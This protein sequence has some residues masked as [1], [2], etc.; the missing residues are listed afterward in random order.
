MSANED[1]E[2]TMVAEP[3]IL[4]SPAILATYVERAKNGDEESF[5]KLVECFSKLILDIVS[6]E[7][8]CKEDVE[9]IWLETFEKA[10]DKLSSLRDTLKF[11]S[12]L[13]AIARHLSR[14]YLRRKREVPFSSLEGNGE[15]EGQFEA[16]DEKAERAY[17]DVIKVLWAAELLTRLPSRMQ[18]C[19][20]LADQYGYTQRQ[21]AE[22]LGISEKTVSVYLSQAREKLR[23][24]KHEWESCESCS[25]QAKSRE[26]A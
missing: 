11:K 25:D 7:T 9:E 2:I 8:Q 23:S 24:W 13:C 22:K 17:E 14:D 10:W 21:I 6:Q 4:R 16:C 12:W 3:V 19:V 1:P 20:C 26:S 15:M 18:V 5:E